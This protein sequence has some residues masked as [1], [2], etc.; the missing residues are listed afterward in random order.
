MALLTRGLCA[1]LPARL[2]AGG[3]RARA[4]R[5]ARSVTYASD[6]PP[7][8]AT[9]ARVYTSFDI[10]KGKSAMNVKVIP[11]TF[12]Q[13]GSS[14]ALSLKRAGTLLLEC[15]PGANRQY[16][17]SKKLAMALSVNEIADVLVYSAEAG[18]APLEF[19]CVALGI[20]HSFLRADAHAAGTTPPWALRTRGRRRSSCA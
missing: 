3:L 10:F 14:G 15:A 16:D 2:A 13:A 5:L 4:P 18:A 9:S 1:S 20:S 8:G 7:E 11:P 6:A 17:W 19:L 12:T